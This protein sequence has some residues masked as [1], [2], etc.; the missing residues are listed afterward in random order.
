VVS[1]EVAEHL[2]ERSAGGFVAALVSLGDVVLFSGSLRRLREHYRSARITLCVRRYVASLVEYCPH[3]DEVVY[4]EDLHATWPRW[5]RRVRGLTRLELGIRR[6][7]IRARYASDV[8]L[9]PLRAPAAE[10]HATLMTVPARERYGISG[11]HA[12]QSPEVDRAVTEIYTQ[13]LVLGPERDAEHELDVNRD[14]LTMLGVETGGVRQ[15]PEVWTA[16]DDREWATSQPWRA[17]GTMLIAIT[18]GVTAPLEKVYPPDRYGAVLDLAGERR[19]SVVILGA[20]GDEAV[21]DETERALARAAKVERITNLVGRT[22]VRQMVECLRAADLI[23]GPDSAPMHVGIALGKPT[24]TIVGG[25]Q[26]GRFHPWGDPE[27]NRVVNKPM[28]CYG[29]HWVCRYPTMRCV[30][31]IGVEEV[32]R[33]LDEALCG[34][35]QAGQVM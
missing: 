11:C 14:F 24:V 17:Q 22:S 31:E 2:P 29:C 26:Y 13:R 23:L 7:Q 28:D 25:G 21:C 15:P 4:W 20:P 9:L 6:R 5:T 33:A 35:S 32:A 27:L 10:M 3:V 12:N 30:Q 1:L 16:P 34:I 19:I 18:P 8:A